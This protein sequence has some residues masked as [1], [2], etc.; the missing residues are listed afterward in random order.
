MIS[1]LVKLTGT[2]YRTASIPDLAE[3]ASLHLC[4]IIIIIGSGVVLLFHNNY[5]STTTTTI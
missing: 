2:M 5:T 1:L 3:L 4:S